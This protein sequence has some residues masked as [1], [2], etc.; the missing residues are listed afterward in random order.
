MV[1][2]Y[3]GIGTNKGDRRK[4]LTDALSL[5]EEKAGLITRSSSVYE[6]EPWGFESEQF[7]LNMVVQ[8]E[9]ELSPPELLDAVHGIEAELGRKRGK[10]RFV[11]RVMDIDI[12]FYGDEVISTEVLVVPHPLISERKF[13]LVPLAE[14]DP[15]LLHPII[16]K[17]VSE[18]LTSC[19]DKSKVI[20]VE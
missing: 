15:S 20:R 12:L 14:T 3:L 1:T 7:F 13:V 17:T 10:T 18:I 19:R 16:K 8:V 2:T 11:S 9:T 6:T 4:N 5:L